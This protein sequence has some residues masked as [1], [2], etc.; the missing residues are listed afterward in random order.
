MSYDVSCRLLRQHTLVSSKSP[1]AAG[2]REKTGACHD[3]KRGKEE[4]Q[5][6]HH[7][8]YV[9]KEKSNSKPLPAVQNNNGDGEKSTVMLDST[10]SWTRLWNWHSTVT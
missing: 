6:R 4:D 10:V 5:S 7:D 9:E 1:E 3:M 2:S 8:M